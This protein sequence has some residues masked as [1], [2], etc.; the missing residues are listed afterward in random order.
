VVM[1]SW[2]RMLEMDTF[3]STVARDFVQLNRNQSPEPHAE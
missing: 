3:D 2:G 1:T